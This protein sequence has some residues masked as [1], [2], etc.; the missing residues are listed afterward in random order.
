MDRMAFPPCLC[1]C[2]LCRPC[3]V[4]D[5]VPGETGPEDC[6]PFEGVVVVVP[7]LCV[8]EVRPAGLG[9]GFAACVPF[10]G[11][12]P[13]PEVVLPVA[14]VTF[15]APEDVG[16]AGDDVDDGGGVGSRHGFDAAREKLLVVAPPFGWCRHEPDVP[17]V[18]EGVGVGGGGDVAGVVGVVVPV[19]TGVVGE[20]VGGSVAGLLGWACVGLALVSGGLAGVHD[21]V[22][23]GL[24][25][26]VFPLA[27]PPLPLPLPDN[28]P[29]PF[30]PP[31]PLPPLPDVG[32][33]FE[34]DPML[35]IACRT[36]GT[37]MAVPVK[38]N[39]AARAMTGLNQAGPTRWRAERA[40]D[41]V[42]ARACRLTVEVPAA[43]VAARPAASAPHRRKGSRRTVPDIH[44]NTRNS[45]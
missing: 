6:V 1:L 10:R 35:L 30:V 20:T 34:D 15:D 29:L 41:L 22:G 38:R 7:A 13:E 31:V 2:P 43:A 45:G 39:T 14:G 42:A 19:G 3:F 36:P 18:S 27:P 23:E 8:G 25:V 9:D 16:E 33:L 21:D 11:D 4:L 24:A 26:L 44:S 28:C 17:E 5:G 32:P 12:D 37:A 40:P